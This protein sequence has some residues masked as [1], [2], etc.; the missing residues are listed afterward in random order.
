VRPLKHKNTFIHAAAGIGH[1]FRKEANFRI[2]VLVMALVMALAV[3]LQI[4]ATE[5]LFVTGCCMLVL[6]MELI[7]TAIE[8]LCDLVSGEYHPLIKTIKDVAAG[9]VLVS[10]VGSI[11]TGGII[12][13]PKIIHQIK[14][15]SC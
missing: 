3:V 2:H 4:S 12:F 6:T 9:A 1:T 8:N 10:A 13:L 5:W 14:Y 15:L 11:I 7:N